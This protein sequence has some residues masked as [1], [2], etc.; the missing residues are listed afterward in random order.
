MIRKCSCA[1]VCGAILRHWCR[2]ICGGER[3]EWLERNPPPPISFLTGPDFPN[4]PI[5]LVAGRDE[6]RSQR[7]Q[8]EKILEDLKDRNSLLENDMR[9]VRVRGRGR[10]Q[11]R[12]SPKGLLFSLSSSSV[13]LPELTTPPPSRPS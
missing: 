1:P 8:Y 12:G 4:L 13:P 5:L 2:C 7:E 3:E 11:E 9:A 6:R 10:Q